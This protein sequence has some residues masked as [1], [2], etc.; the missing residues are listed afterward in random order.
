MLTMNIRS[1]DDLFD[2]L[3]AHHDSRSKPAF[4]IFSENHPKRILQPKFPSFP[5]P[6]D[7][8]KKDFDSEI[9]RIPTST[10]GLYSAEELKEDALWLS[11]QVDL[12]EQDA[13]RLVV[14]EWQCRPEARLRQGYT[15]AEVASL[16]VALGSDYMDRHIQRKEGSLVRDEMAFDSRNSRLARLLHSHL[17]QQVLALRLG[18]ELSELSVP[19][20][21]NEPSS[22]KAPKILADEVRTRRY[23]LADVFADGAQHIRM[24]LQSLESGHSWEIDEPEL[25]LLKDARVVAALQMIGAILEILLITLRS[26]DKKDEKPLSD[27]VSLWFQL[28]SSM[29]FFAPF[30][31]ETDVQAAAIHKIQST[32]SL[33]TLTLLD[34]GSTISI[35]NQAA[36]ASQ[37]VPPGSR[38]E[39]F[40][41]V[42]TAPQVHEVL[43]SEAA[44]GNMQAGP[45]ILAWAIIVH[46]V[47]LLAS[48]IKEKRES[49]HV[50]RTLET[51]ATFDAA[52]GRR[53][54]SGVS[55][56]FQTTI[57]EELM[58][59]F[60]LQ[61]PND[62]ASSLLLDAAIDRCNLV[63]YIALLSAS[64]GTPSKI[65]SVYKLQALQELIE[66][67]QSFLGYTPELVASQLALLAARGGSTSEKKLYDVASEAI[68][69]NSLRQGFYD[70]SAARFP[71]ECLPFLQFSRA[72]AKAPIFSEDGTQ[73]V[74][75][76]L[77]KL[78]SFTQAAVKGIEYRTTHE[79]ELVSQVALN[80][81]VNLLDLSQKK[82]LTY[83]Y[84]E[85]ETTAIIPADTIG[86][87]ISDPDAT[88][89]V[90]RWRHEYSCLAYMGQLLELHYMGLL[91]TSL[92]PSEDA[93]AVVSEI[94]GLLT[95]LLSS[96]L[97]NP[98]SP[99]T[100]DEAQQHCIA[101]LGEASC[102]LNPE[103]DV[104]LYI[105]DV[106]EQELQSF[107]R[108]T[109][110]TFDCRI[111]ISC[112]DFI[113]A[114]TKI[115]P[116]LIWSSL[117]RTSLL[118][119][120]S[121]SSPILGIV[122][123]VEVP[124]HNFDLLE[125]ITN[126]YQSLTD[127]ALRHADIGTSA[128]TGSLPRRSAV[129]PAWRIQ[130]PMILVATEVMF[131]VF[132]G[133]SAWSF[134]D[135]DQQLRMS[136]T[137][138]E[139]FSD[140]IRY[141]FGVGSSLATPSA[142]TSP[143]LEAATFLISSFR[144]SDPQNAG[145]NSI[146]QILSE[147][148]TTGKS[149][150]HGEGGAFEQHI[151][152]VLT[153]ATLL[154]RY[155]QVQNLPLSSLETHIFNAVPC[156]VRLLQASSSVPTQCLRLM[157]S[158]L[159]SV[160]SH[161]P[162][163]LL[164]HLGSASCIDLL[165]LLRHLNQ[166]S[167][168]SDECV[169][170]W[171]LLVL[172]VK[173]SQQWLAMVILT[174]A[175][176]DSSKGAMSETKTSKRVRGKT[177]LHIAMDELKDLSKLPKKVAIA[178]LEFVAEAQ[179]NWSWVT[180]DLSSSE[181]F[182][183]KVVL[184]VTSNK[185]ERYQGTDLAEHNL[186]TA[187]VTDIA[188]THLHH[189]K[190]SRDL[191]AVKT[192]IPLVDWL[193]T[194]AIEVSS[195]NASLHANLGRNFSAKYNGLTVSDLKQ[196]GLTE[197][198]YGPSFFYYDVDFA[199]KLLGYG[200]SWHGGRGRAAFQSFSAEFGRAN[201]NLSVV[202]S[203]L[204]LLSSFERLCIDH[205]KFFVQDREVQRAMAHIVGNCL[206][207]NS[208]VCPTEPLFGSLFQ[209]RADLSIALLRELVAFGAKGSD[210]VGLLEHAWSA[211]RFRNES[212]EQAIIN[213]DLIY[214]R[215][216]LTV[217]LMTIQFHV[218]KKRKPVIVPGSTAA[219][220]TLNPENATFLEIATKIV[221]E[222]FGSV[223]V[224]LQD[225]KGKK[226]KTDA[227][228]QPDLV[229]LRDISILLT[230]TQTILK[231]PSLPQF[232][233]ELSER[234]SSSGIISS[235]LVL[236]SWS[237]LFAR[238]EEDSH[239][240][241]ADYCVRLLA[242]ISS[243][244]P[245]AEELAIDG[246][247]NRLLTAKTTETLQVV[248]G[249]ASHAD[250]RPNCAFLY[251]IWATG[252][253]P[254]CLN[255]LHAVGAA[256]APEVSAFLNRF[257]NQLIRA[258]TS[259]MPTPQTKAASGNV[260]TLAVASEAATLALISYVLSSYRAAGASAAVDPTTILPLTGYDEH[261]KA[262]VEDLGDLVA[263]KEEARRKMTVPTDEKE[264][265]W[266]NAKD[267]DIL[268]AKIVKDLK[269]AVV[270]LSKDDE[271]NE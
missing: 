111:M 140:I 186:L 237:H 48:A 139:S 191:D 69:Q 107:R 169:Q 250:I 68:E 95:I 18:R 88:P 55:S 167:K 160:E 102:N 133:L 5:P 11:T 32:A 225:Q 78:T 235:C 44:R 266:Q 265:S 33:I 228:Q 209:T 98:S 173:E 66:V 96:S 240:R 23:E 16:K 212:Y 165:N 142:A 38:A 202:D 52:T 79:D 28:M 60:T 214:W 188:T 184:T 263:M 124:L 93:Q 170:L 41:D 134:E 255:L 178:M 63:D 73:Y 57:F 195:Y 12:N 104:I 1:W 242:S 53:S 15:E 90:I 100:A 208:Q 147:V 108:R 22:R 206:Q 8:S 226:L 13:L 144:T 121:A 37:V 75:F 175:A 31:S 151:N 148:A 261:R 201:T 62:D 218:H 10:D 243:L 153:L 179:Q 171:K 110:P 34:V 236:Y 249:G 42:A 217:L 152:S 118:G 257:P 7:S 26:P 67:A 126:M 21:A 72:L 159:V 183:S 205:C 74:E 14:L 71:Y 168:S 39:Y 143:F 4:Q 213:N 221:A 81:S 82:L 91:A 135:P 211:V 130:S 232:A 101:M 233:A 127:L 239:P 200:S 114:L 112:V 198:E 248:P 47:K 25:G 230:V 61:T 51:V 207:A 164:G 116:D 252:L 247:L 83:A 19:L 251:R 59:M 129:P 192:Y 113:V 85:S 117:G 46:Q 145:V 210:F 103:A 270:A 199:E 138:N 246:V 2:A 181:D 64:A 260:L 35:L 94:V 87:V 227:E 86:E 193:A 122:A 9:A 174:G 17:H 190:I 128:A 197:R 162:S 149:F 45:A 189:A 92:S 155:G 177:F 216:S 185:S 150:P 6:S 187:Y 123:A 166:N 219:L 119:H 154:T 163:S 105:F 56:A 172:L 89:K 125:S 264:S 254:V 146:T 220:V 222:G 80:R 269:V 194:N 204:A 253:L 76:R 259:L 238:P 65:L 224:A 84:Q 141:A 97:N 156:L 176:P 245:V 106:L 234:L 58:D 115:R 131:Q 203:Q 196:T 132:Q 27:T 30:N 231:L 77:R 54:S 262:I 241:Y 99:P 267:G 258:S 137:I 50:Q 158:I 180:K 109:V 271:E 40:F 136:T 157:R 244:P 215:S 29:G 24:Q 49:Q 229:G 20:G 120:Q 223:V 268:D 36:L 161:Q 182:F 43:V 256:V 3:F 70:M